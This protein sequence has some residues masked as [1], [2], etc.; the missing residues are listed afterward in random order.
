M[1]DDDAECLG[2]LVEVCSDWDG[3]SKECSLDVLD[4]ALSHQCAIDGHLP[5]LVRNLESQLGDDHFDHGVVL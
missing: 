3:S 1:A 4:Q 5:V 2:P